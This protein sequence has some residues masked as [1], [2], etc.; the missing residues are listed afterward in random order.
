MDSD[1]AAVAQPYSQFNFKVSVS[2]IL[3]GFQELTGVDADITKPST[4]VTLKR[5]VMNGA[6]LLEWMHAGARRTV[7]IELQGE[8]HQT[9]ARWVLSEARPVRS[10]F[11][12]PNSTEPDAAIEELV[13]SYERMEFVPIG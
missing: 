13:L 10:T 3:G 6:A 11:A 2:S 8:M 9:V 1:V 7:T 4:E 12:E 5:G